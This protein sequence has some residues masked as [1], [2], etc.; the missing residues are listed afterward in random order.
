LQLNIKKE[1]VP[2]P[3]IPETVDHQYAAP[4]QRVEKKKLDCS[5]DT[6]GTS[7]EKSQP[8]MRDVGV[9]ANPHIPHPDPPQLDLTC[10]C[11]S[12]MALVP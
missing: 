9:Q 2:M 6:A 5:K 8:E 1:T 12:S 10:C 7:K 11:C 3:L 4:A